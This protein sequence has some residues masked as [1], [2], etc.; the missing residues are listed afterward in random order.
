[1]FGIVSKTVRRRGRAKDPFT[2]LSGNDG[3]PLES[4]AVGTAMREVLS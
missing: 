2:L 1:M 3:D 4:A